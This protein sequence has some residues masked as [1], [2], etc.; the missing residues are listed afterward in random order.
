MGYLA[1][2]LVAK[3]L[4]REEGSMAKS[5]VGKYRY[6]TYS[7]TKSVSLG[8]FRELFAGRGWSERMHL[9]GDLVD[10]GWLWPSNTSLLQFHPTI[11]QSQ[12]S[13]YGIVLI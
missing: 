9:R 4:S 11:Y 5:T 13:T 7:F 3:G 8:F 1:I 2:V 10:F 6:Y 12:P